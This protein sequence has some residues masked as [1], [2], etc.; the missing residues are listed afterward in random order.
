MGVTTI[1]AL[2]ALLYSTAVTAHDHQMDTIPEGE[3]ISPD[4][5]VR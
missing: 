2:A 1:P 4:P 3:A 5:I